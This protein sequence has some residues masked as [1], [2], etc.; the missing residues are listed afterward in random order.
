VWSS[1]DA[2]EAGVREDEPFGSC[3]VFNFGLAVKL[4]RLSERR[5]YFDAAL[6]TLILGVVDSPDVVALVDD[7]IPKPATRNAFSVASWDC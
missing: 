2:P 4:S 6:A 1:L 7:C 3:M 5:L